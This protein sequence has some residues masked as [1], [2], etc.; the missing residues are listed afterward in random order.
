MT[1]YKIVDDSNEEK[2][3]KSEESFRKIIEEV[4][5]KAAKKRE[6]E[7]M[8]REIVG[9]DGKARKFMDIINKGGSV[10]VTC[11]DGKCSGSGHSHEMV[12]EGDVLKCTGDD[13]GKVYKL[14]PEDVAKEVAGYKCEKCGKDHLRPLSKKL[15]KDDTCLNCGSDKFVKK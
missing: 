1:N 14:I 11:P 10:G 9:K 2:N 4:T 6:E 15:Q 5:E 13:C 8:N 12:R 7:V 3:E